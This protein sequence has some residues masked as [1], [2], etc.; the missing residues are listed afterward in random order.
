MAKFDQT[1]RGGVIAQPTEAAWGVLWF[2]GE[3]S[4]RRLSTR[5]LGLNL[6]T[7]LCYSRPGDFPAGPTVGLEHETTAALSADSDLQVRPQK[8]N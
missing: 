5:L 8:V 2:W 1:I 7:S 6:D 3:H 4:L